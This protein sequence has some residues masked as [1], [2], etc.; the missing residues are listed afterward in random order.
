M[1]CIKLSGKA[2]KRQTQASILRTEFGL[3]VDAPMDAHWYS[4]PRCLLR[5][6]LDEAALRMSCVTPPDAMNH[7]VVA[8]TA[9][10][11][12]NGLFVS[13]S[14]L[15]H[16]STLS[17]VGPGQGT[18]SVKRLPTLE[19]TLAAGRCSSL[20]TLCSALRSLDAT[21]SSAQGGSVLP[22]GAHDAQV[23][24]HQLL[25][26]FLLEALAPFVLLQVR[27]V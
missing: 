22:A 10:L 7:L 15:Y 8:F 26:A 11:Q 4:S 25:Q 16:V 21:G 23:L 6:H 18:W 1:I 27:S 12:V 24:N 14:R 13:L 3:C 5:V 19:R 9:V 17:F 2:G 20:D